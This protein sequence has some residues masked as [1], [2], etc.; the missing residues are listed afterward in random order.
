MKKRLILL[1]LLILLPAF[2]S[3]SSKKIT[4]SW[5]QGDVVICPHCGREHILPEKLG[6]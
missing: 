2:S 3:C 6:K 1:L 4:K 5:N